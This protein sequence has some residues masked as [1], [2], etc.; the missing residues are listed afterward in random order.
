MILSSQNG[1]DAVLKGAEGGEEFLIDDSDEDMPFD[2]SAP[3]SRI[4]KDLSNH[5]ERYAISYVTHCM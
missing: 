4:L 3:L 1:L 5:D 2:P